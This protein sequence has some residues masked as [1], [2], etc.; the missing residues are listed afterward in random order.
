M[1]SEASDKIMPDARDLRDASN[2]DKSQHKLRERCIAFRVAGECYA[3]EL[4]V[5]KDVILRPAIVPVPGA[6][7]EILGVMNLRGNVVTVLNGREVLN[8][9][10]VAEGPQARVLVLEEE[11]HE[12]GVLVDAVEDMVD[13]DVEQLDAV[14]R[15]KVA[16]S[17]R[18]RRAVMLCEEIVFLLHRS[19][20]T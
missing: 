7:P 16:T 14:P 17:T 15:D 1:G 10:G 11:G 12:V 20:P 9:P 6:G 8:L 19:R 18:V 4:A 3:I 2:I 5:V 13:V